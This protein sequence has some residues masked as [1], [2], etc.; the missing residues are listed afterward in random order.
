MIPYAIIPLLDLSDHTWSIWF[1][2]RYWLIHME[3]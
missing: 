3:P 1:V 2:V